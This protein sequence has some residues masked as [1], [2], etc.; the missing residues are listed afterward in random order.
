[1]AVTKG[2]LS[3][4][5]IYRASIMWNNGHGTLRIATVL[6]V[7]ESRV[8]NMLDFIKNRATYTKR[9]S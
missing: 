3:S 2:I 1:M 4:D 7:N 5:Q 6:G 9:V 8:W